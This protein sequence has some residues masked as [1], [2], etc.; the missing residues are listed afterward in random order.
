MLH[1]TQTTA[2]LEV[3]LLAGAETSGPCVSWAGTSE[4]IFRSQRSFSIV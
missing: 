1:K 2:G 3:P 4:T